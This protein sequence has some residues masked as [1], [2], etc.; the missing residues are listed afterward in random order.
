[1][2]VLVTGAGGFL[3]S[4][5]VERLLAEEAEVH[6]VSRS[7]RE[8]QEGGVRWWQADLAELDSTRALFASVAPDLVF[9]MAGLATSAPGLELV[10]PMFRG[11][12]MTT[13]NLLTAAT[14][15]GS[16]RVLLA[17]SLTEPETGEPARSPYAVSKWAASGYARMF[18][19]LYGTRPSVCA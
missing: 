15:A 5:L 1:M 4:R 9:G 14:E 8:T 13:V 18:H 10:P 16:P 19:S 7:P 3:G 11:N 6:A 12:L 17:Q 2:R